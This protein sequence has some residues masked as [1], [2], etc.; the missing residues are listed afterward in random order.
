MKK[1][2]S[3]LL[4]RRSKPPELATAYFRL[5]EPGVW[6]IRGAGAMYGGPHAIP[7]HPRLEAILEAL[8][9]DQIPVDRVWSGSPVN[10]DEYTFTAEFDDG[11]LSVTTG[12]YW[13][14]PR[15]GT[16]SGRLALGRLV[17][18]LNLR[19]PSRTAR[20]WG[21]ATADTADARRP[22]P[23]DRHGNP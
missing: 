12:T 19:L 21:L 4:R 2:K 3:R 15:G 5:A 13:G 22:A 10:A 6:A 18:L 17:R 14:S 23:Q 20:A 8:N 11:G 7:M 9:R 1:S 16:I